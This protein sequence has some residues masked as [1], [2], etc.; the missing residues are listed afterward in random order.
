MIQDARLH[1]RLTGAQREAIEKAAAADSRSI[2]SY[3]VIAA[4]EKASKPSPEGKR[5][6]KP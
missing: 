5:E 6:A 4:L 1:I 3:V 2:S